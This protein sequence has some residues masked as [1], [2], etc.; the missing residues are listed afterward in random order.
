MYFFLKFDQLKRGKARSQQ[1]WFPYEQDDNDQKCKL[2][3]YSRDAR[4]YYQTGENVVDG[5]RCSYDK[6]NDICVQGKCVPL[7]CDK[8]PY[9]CTITSFSNQIAKLPIMKL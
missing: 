8:V 1:T 2:T 6:A 5:T 3:C 7:G 4:E 9:F